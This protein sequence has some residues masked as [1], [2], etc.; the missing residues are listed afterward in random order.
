MG[1]GLLKSGKKLPTFV[2]LHFFSLGG[3]ISFLGVFPAC[4]LSKRR[5]VH[6]LILTQP[7]LRSLMDLRSLKLRL[8]SP[9][10]RKYSSL[11]PLRLSRP[12]RL[13]RSENR[14]VNAWTPPSP[15]LYCNTQSGPNKLGHATS[16]IDSA[17]PLPVAAINL[18]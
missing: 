5:L 15:F 3:M 10:L 8:S 4:R 12:D 16:S 2:S 7:S 9:P 1:T 17:R 18:F 11:W 14:R 6:S 13:S